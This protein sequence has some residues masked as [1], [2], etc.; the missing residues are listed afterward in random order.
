MATWGAHIRI[1]E[2]ILNADSSLDEKAFLVG[3]IGPD[4]GEP[5]EDRSEF[6]P[7]KKVSHWI[8]EDKKIDADKFYDKYKGW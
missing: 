4:C 8:N 6:F 1:A 2:A 7:S 3:N 5:Y